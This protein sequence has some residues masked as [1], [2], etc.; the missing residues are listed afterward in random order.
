MYYRINS[1]LSDKMRVY[2]E[3]L[4]DVNHP[5]YGIIKVEVRSPWVRDYFKIENGNIKNISICLKLH[6]Q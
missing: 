2:K 3:K 1:E 4:L 6:L 5:A